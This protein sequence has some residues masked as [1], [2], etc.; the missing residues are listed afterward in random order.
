MLAW[1][2]GIDNGRQKT[3]NHGYDVIVGGE[4]FTDYPITL[5]TCHAKPKNSNQQAPDATSSFPLVGCLPQAA[6]PKDF[7]P[8][9]QDAVALQQIKERGALPMIDRGDIRQAI[10]LLYNIWG[11]TAGR[12]LC[13]LSINNSPIAKFVKKRAER[14][15][16]LMYEQSHRDYLRSGYLHHRLLVMAANHYRDNAITYKAQR[17]KKCQRT[18]AGERGNY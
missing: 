14:S 10:D 15:E 18:E 12:W 8:K 7:S 2:E 6:Y 9:S 11:F 3:R 16:R 4:S 13:C 1:S 17:D 5:Q